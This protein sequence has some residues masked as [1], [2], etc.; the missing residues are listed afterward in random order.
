[1]LV[2]DTTSGTGDLGYLHC[3]PSEGQYGFDFIRVIT[4]L[5]KS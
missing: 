1:M 4:G 2:G 3:V 5:A